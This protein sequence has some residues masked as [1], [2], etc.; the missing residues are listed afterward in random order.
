MSF[1][2]ASL[3][4]YTSTTDSDNNVSKN[5]SDLFWKIIDLER[6]K[7]NILFF[8]GYNFYKIIKV[9][10]PLPSESGSCALKHGCV[11]FIFARCGF[12]DT[13]IS[14][15]V[16]NCDSYQPFEERIHLIYLFPFTFKQNSKR[17]S[18]TKTHTY[19]LFVLTLLNLLL[20]LK[21]FQV[22]LLSFVC[23]W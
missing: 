13:V 20:V 23:K 22:I 3:V 11:L 5:S 4:H 18:N 17:K 6:K 15:S 12:W 14:S 7:R 1:A 9:L 2:I 19:K 8:R 21:Y 16:F 10:F